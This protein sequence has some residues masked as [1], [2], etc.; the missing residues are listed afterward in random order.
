MH[1]LTVI[2]QGAQLR[3]PKLTYNYSTTN[4][5]NWLFTLKIMIMHAA[6]INCVACVGVACVGVA[7][8]GFACVD[9]ACVVGG[10]IVRLYRILACTRNS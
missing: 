7:C 9:V 2:G 5:S 1:A 8:V 10:E 3:E 4:S 6:M